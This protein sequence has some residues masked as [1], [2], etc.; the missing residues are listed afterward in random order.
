M[1]SVHQYYSCMLW[2][3]LELSPR[4]GICQ[5]F[6]AIRIPQSFNYTR[7]T[8]KLWQYSGEIFSK[9]RVVLKNLEFSSRISHVWGCPLLDIQKCAWANRQHHSNWETN[10]ALRSSRFGRTMILG[11]AYESFGWLWVE[12]AGAYETLKCFSSARK[13]GGGPCEMLRV[14]WITIGKQFFTSSRN[15]RCVGSGYASDRSWKANRMTWYFK[16]VFTTEK[17]CSLLAPKVLV[18]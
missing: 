10:I 2:I 8:R 4:H 9:E 1:L 15:S 12:A 13:V 3:I 5:I 16:R 6:F 11:R 14:L 17:R 18:E 7:K